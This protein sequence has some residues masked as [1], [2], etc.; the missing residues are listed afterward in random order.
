MSGFVWNIIEVITNFLE[1]YLLCIFI[2]IFNEKFTK[3]KKLFFIV[4][5]A[6]VLTILN[7]FFPV[8]SI[9]TLFIIMFFTLMVMTIFYGKERWK[10]NFFIIC[11]YYII[12][13]ISELVTAIIIMVILNK[14]PNNIFNQTDSRLIAIVI[15]KLLTFFVIK[16]INYR[17][18]KIGID[19]KINIYKLAIVFFLNITI[20][21]IIYDLYR[22]ININDMK[23]FY[24]IIIV[25]III[26]II[27]V[28]IFNISNILASLLEKE[29]EYSI[30]TDH[31]IEQK[32]QIE[33]LNELLIEV[34]KK[35]H[36]YNNN[37]ST[38]YAMMSKVEHKT[39]ENFLE[40]LIEETAITTETISKNNSIISVITNYKLQKAESENIK[41]DVNVDIPDD[42][43][44][45]EKD[46]A[47]ILGNI[48][49]NA[50]EACI[51]VEE[52]KRYIIINI[53]IKKGYLNIYLEN[54]SK[55]NYNKKGDKFVTT[56][57][58]NVRSH[59]IGLSNVKYIV[60]RNNGIIEIIA[61]GYRF[62]I[63]ISII[64]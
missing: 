34:R 52:E 27:D 28:I 53:G 8:A 48:L 21:F 2:E 5:Q 13:T 16:N 30:Q 3:Y 10:Q 19:K 38:I 35:Q 57:R 50:I 29:I 17:R 40:G 4:S 18:L 45:D 24:T 32:K 14:N 25:S 64:F 62:I 55:G 49:D 51:N 9:I 20:T 44:I 12:V 1:M 47:T 33:Q 22:K 43:I 7:N 36:D 61:E 15:C 46:I 60:E 42:L 59:G 11:L 54:S 23:N 26:I 37:L 39:I 6:L 58:R 56:K 31:Y 41:L 63:K